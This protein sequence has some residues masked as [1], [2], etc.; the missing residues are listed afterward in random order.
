MKKK[1]ILL[2]AIVF[3]VLVMGQSKKFEYTPKVKNK[4]EIKN[5]LGS[6]SIQ[7][8]TGNAIVIESDFDLEKPERAEGLKLLGAFDDNT[9]IGLNVGED[10][11]IVS[12]QGAIKQVRDFNYKILV[13]AGMAVNLDYNS[14]FA[15]GNITIDSYNGSL[16]VN[17][18][19]ANVKL[20][21][22]L[23]P[24][25]VSSVSGNI[26]VTFSKINQDGPTSLASVSGFIDVTVPAN[27]KATFELSNISGNVYN[28][29]DLK[30]LSGDEKDK[31]ASGLEPIKHNDGNDFTMNGGGQ[32]VYLKTISGNIYLRKR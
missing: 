21:N 30:S 11:G 3:P 8:S 17:T 5:L 12:I 26:E 18:L 14:P 27:E 31:R 32:K 7:N 19:S 16:E 6:I 24:F 9:E 22:S 1:V 25:T 4:I 15:R 28:N 13:P 20:I 23:G 29:L 10:N 2:A